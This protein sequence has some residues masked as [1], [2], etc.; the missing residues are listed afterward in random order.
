MIL[1]FKD[2][3]LNLRFLYYGYFQSCNQYLLLSLASFLKGHDFM[4]FVVFIEDAVNAEHLL[5]QVAKGLET[6]VIVR[7]AVVNDVILNS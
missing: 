4:A 6:F 3:V 5:V 1:Y 7:F 2:D